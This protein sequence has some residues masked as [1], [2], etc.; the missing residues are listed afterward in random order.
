MAWLFLQNLV[1]VEKDL[2][3][4][5]FS[6][7]WSENKPQQT[8]L[9]ILDFKS[10]AAVCWTMNITAVTKVLLYF[11]SLWGVQ[12]DLSMTTG[13]ICSEVI[14]GIKSLLFLDL[15]TV[16]WIIFHKKSF[17]CI[18]T[19]LYC[20]L[21]IT[22]SASAGGWNLLALPKV[23]L[24]CLVWQYWKQSC[25]DFFP[26]FANGKSIL[27][28]RTGTTIWVITRFVTPSHFTCQES[29]LRKTDFA[30]KYLNCCN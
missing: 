11:L 4:I 16:R 27:Y 19:F 23:H 17:K 14:N 26:P 18:R 24:F 29:Q 10:H 12:G 28:I 13:G 30:L 3:L 22:S 5:H 2:F 6:Y 21:L 7:F 20:T 9:K 15:C 8:A 1:K 25:I